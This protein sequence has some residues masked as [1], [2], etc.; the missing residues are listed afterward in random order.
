[1]IYFHK[2]SNEIIQPLLNDARTADNYRSGLVFECLVNDFCGKCY[3]CEDK[4]TTIHIDHFKPIAK[5]GEKY[6]WTN[7]YFSCAHCNMTKGAKYWPLLDCT[8]ETNK[9]WE[10]IEIK[11]VSFFPRLSLEVIAHPFP[12]KE[13]ECINTCRL[14]SACIN[15]TTQIKRM[16]AE[17]L[18]QRML[19][20]YKEL[21]KAINSGN[22][23]AIRTLISDTA[24]FAG[25]QRWTLKNERPELFNRLLG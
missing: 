6:S 12:G 9:V 25:M 19:V 3:L 4:A 7:L 15:G 5:G 13:T 11:P 16:E 10:S 22:I 23:G 14:V 20:V 8:Q 18:R 2:T 21:F 17:H 24:P 1:M